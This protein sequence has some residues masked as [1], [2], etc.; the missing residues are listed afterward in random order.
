M[1]K[2][3]DDIFQASPSDDASLVYDLLGRQVSD[4]MKAV[5]DQSFTKS[6][7]KKWSLFQI[8]PSKTP[9]LDGLTPLFFQKFWG[10][11][12]RDVSEAI[13]S[14]L[15]SGNLLKKVNFTHLTLIPKKKYFKDPISTQSVS[16]TFYIK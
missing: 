4:E 7:V 11:M 5:L 14:F 1:L 15:S 2:N 3:F 12:G 10:I 13:I 9:G 8:H 16:T 6:E